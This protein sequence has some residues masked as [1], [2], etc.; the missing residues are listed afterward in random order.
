MNQ[1][2]NLDHNSLGLTLSR[3][4]F[5][6][7][8]SHNYLSVTSSDVCKVSRKSL[9]AKISKARSRRYSVSNFYSCFENS[10]L[11][12]VLT[13]YAPKWR[14]KKFVSDKKTYLISK[15]ILTSTKKCVC[16]LFAGGSFPSYWCCLSISHF[17][18]ASAPI[19]YNSSVLKRV[20]FHFFQEIC[21]VC[22]K[23][24]LRPATF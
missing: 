18:P 7:T 5:R 10:T 14:K 21:F 19:L 11:W 22:K 1:P 17:A 13:K 24:D 2:L 9:L 12:G 20:L 3:N 23:G 16:L 6:V 8:F 15:S 4:P